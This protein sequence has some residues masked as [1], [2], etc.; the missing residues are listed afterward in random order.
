M[1]L[2]FP[3]WFL[4]QSSQYQNWKANK[5]SILTLIELMLPVSVSSTG[6]QNFMPP[7]I[8]NTKFSKLESRIG[9]PMDLIWDCLNW[10][11]ALTTITLCSTTN[12]ECLMVYIPIHKESHLRHFTSLKLSKCYQ[13]PPPLHHSE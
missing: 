6:S 11:L 12:G 13:I 8:L 4:T 2:P 10:E 5:F 9:Y 7:L 1:L 3:Q